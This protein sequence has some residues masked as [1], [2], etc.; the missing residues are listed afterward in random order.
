MFR[1]NVAMRMLPILA[2]VA[3]CVW[4]LA[5]PGRP[6]TPWDELLARVAEGDAA[7]A[8]EAIAIASARSTERQHEYTALAQHT[9]P[10]LRALAQRLLA[11]DPAAHLIDLLRG[12]S[13]RDFRVRA[14]S[15]AALRHL[16]AGF[17]APH[18]DTPLRERDAH[19]LEWLATLEHPLA[20][21]PQLL[22]AVFAAPQ[23]LQLGTPILDRC[24]TCHAAGTVKTLEA[25]TACAECHATA[26]RQASG[27]AHANTLSHLRLQTVDPVTRTPTVVGFGDRLGI[28]CTACHTSPAAT[29]TSCSAGYAPAQPDRCAD[30]H[31][32]SAGEWR[33]W[34]SSPRPRRATWPPGSIVMTGG[35]AEVVTCASCH[36]RPAR[37][38]EAARSNH[39]WAARRDPALLRSGLDVGIERHLNAND[40]R[41]TITNLAGHA[42]PSGLERRV[43]ELRVAVD[44][45]PTQLVTRL[46]AHP[47]PSRL[48][49]PDA[50]P[51]A[52]A[53][54]RTLSITAPPSASVVRWT[55]TYVRDHH[56]PDLYQVVFAT[57]EAR[58]R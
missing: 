2:A 37:G 16:D 18:R 57:G 34:L 21:D 15:H 26:H 41:V 53:E 28:T 40:L 51:L 31:S 13:D 24:L 20:S 54:R 3:A 39:R 27:S 48:S 11:A 29:P 22:C 10:E 4:L 25:T 35:A 14:A 32:Q 52:P 5:S 46:R 19:L 30:C 36:M 43:I 45:G 1:V 42:A 33:Q 44:D 56:Q 58:F 47:D 9:S 17:E 7:A 23:H 50:P 6:P 8:E 12:A 38:D 49:A 55:L